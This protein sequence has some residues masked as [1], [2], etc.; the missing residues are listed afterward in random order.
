M[1]L[2]P[3]EVSTKMTAFKKDIFTIEPEECVEPLLDDVGYQTVSHGHTRHAIQA[4]L[5]N[6]I[7]LPLFNLIWEGV[8]LKEFKETRE[9]FEKSSK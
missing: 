1:S 6:T 8:F 2:R 9:N 4:W 5:Y 7:P 3:S